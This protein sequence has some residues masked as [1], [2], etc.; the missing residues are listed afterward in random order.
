MY[1][2]REIIVLCLIFLKNASYDIL[3]DKDVPNFINV[4]ICIYDIYT[5]NFF[6]LTFYSYNIFGMFPPHPVC[7]RP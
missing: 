2:P 4:N 6:Y 3:E 1:L 5:F 7:P